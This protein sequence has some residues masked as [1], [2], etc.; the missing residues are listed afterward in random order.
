MIINAPKFSRREDMPASD[1]IHRLREG[2]L[3]VGWRRQKGFALAEVVIAIGIFGLAVPGLLVGLLHS[4]RMAS[5]NRMHTAALAIARTEMEA[6]RSLVPFNPQLNQVPADLAIGSHTTTDVP[7]Y[8]D[9]ADENR[10]IM[11]SITTT[12][13]DPGLSEGGTNLNLR[14]VTVTV[15]FAYR[16]RNYN[17]SLTT[18]RASDL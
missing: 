5:L 14:R 2:I 12:T 17:V 3:K 6:M 11:G 18:L 4:Y 9:P 10:V 8:V 16:G 15:S 1:M 13:A 7:I